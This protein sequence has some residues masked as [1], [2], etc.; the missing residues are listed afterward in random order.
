VAGTDLTGFA[1]DPDLTGFGNLSVLS[2]SFIAPDRP[3]FIIETIKQAE[4]G[5]GLIIRGY[6]SQRQRG[7]IVL[8]TAVPLQS[9]WRTNLLEENEEALPV[10]NNQVR[11]AVRPYEIVTLR[12]VR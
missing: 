1:A 5:N 2:R 7:P 3:N 12:L 9:A 8:E 4:D 10:E 11:F 6:E